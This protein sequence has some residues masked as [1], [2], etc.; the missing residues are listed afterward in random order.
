MSKKAVNKKYYTDRFIS[1]T[2]YEL[3]GWTDVDEFWRGWLIVK[4]GTVVARKEQRP[5]TTRTDS[6]QWVLIRPINMEANAVTYP[7]YSVA[8]LLRKLPTTILDRYELEMITP[9]SDSYA[10]VYRGY[11]GGVPTTPEGFAFEGAPTPE[12]AIAKTAIELFEKG[13]LVRSES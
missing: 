7:A 12:E 6:Y 11:I 2:L 4:A 13:I 5:Y 3:S 10:F 8:Y 9:T 1:K